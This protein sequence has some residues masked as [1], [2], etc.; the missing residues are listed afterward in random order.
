MPQDGNEPFLSVDGT[1]I[2]FEEDWSTGIG[3]GLWSTGKA[4]AM[5]FIENPSVIRNNVKALKIKDPNHG[6][7]AM[8]LGSGNGLLSV[9]LAAVMKDRIKDLVVTDL[10]NHLDLMTKTMIANKHIV[11]LDGNDAADNGRPHLLV[12]QHRWGAFDDALSAEKFDFIFGS[13]V[14][15]RD[16]LH[17]PLIKSLQKFS[18]PGT[19]S[20]IG[21][22]MHDT[23]PSFFKLLKENGFTYQR[24]HEHQM[25]PEFRGTTFG[26]FAIQKLM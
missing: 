4:M 26:L 14:A 17:E 3:G 13:D 9:C 21:V 19:V 16:W 25:A 10:D 22:T 6:V 11:N 1:Q 23:K 24:L 8:E 7:R 15:Y 12:K 5:Y 18:H 20:L 2:F